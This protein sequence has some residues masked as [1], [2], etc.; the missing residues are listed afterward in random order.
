MVEMADNVRAQAHVLVVHVGGEGVATDAGGSLDAPT[1]GIAPAPGATRARRRTDASPERVARVRAMRE[2]V[3]LAIGRD[4]L[5]RTARDVGV[6]T[7]SGLRKFVWSDSLPYRKLWEGLLEWSRRVRPEAVLGPDDEELELAIRVL[8]KELED[9]PRGWAAA[10]E[11]IRASVR[12]AYEGERR[13]TASV[14][15]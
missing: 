9:D 4:G 13:R 2:E 15:V 12:G 8:L 14:A 7:A 3:R 1:T 6:G 10:A 5:R 11:C